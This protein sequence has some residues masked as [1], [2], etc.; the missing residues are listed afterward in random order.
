M[1]KPPLSR[2]TT[3]I[4]QFALQE[5]RQLTLD[6]HAN[7]MKISAQED[8]VGAL[9]IAARRAAI[10]TI[11]ADVA[12]YWVREAAIAEVQRSDGAGSSG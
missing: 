6:L 8:L 4:A 3:S 11:K 7:G 10:D 5:L 1:D 12:A 2:T 9:V